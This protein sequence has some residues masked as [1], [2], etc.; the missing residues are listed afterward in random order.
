[1]P[2]IE[3]HPAFV[4]YFF[5]KEHEPVHVHVRV[6]ERSC[7]IEVG[8]LKVAQNKGFTSGQLRRI[9]AIVRSNEALILEA[10]IEHFEES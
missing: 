7:R 10:W 5:L 3:V 2:R 1:M 8:S 6:G 9:A 4:F